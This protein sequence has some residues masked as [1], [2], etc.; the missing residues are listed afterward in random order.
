MR[1]VSHSTSKSYDISSPA[2]DDAWTTSD[3]SLAIAASEQIEIEIVSQEQQKPKDRRIH[4]VRE[5]FATKK[6]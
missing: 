2:S 6:T 4:K 5:K 1:E 3:S